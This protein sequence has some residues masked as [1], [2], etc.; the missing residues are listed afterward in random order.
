M[1]SYAL[2]WGHHHGSGKS[3]LGYTLL[4][5]FGDNGAEISG[6]EL[7]SA[8]NGYAENKQF[9]MADEC[10]DSDKRLESG[11]FKT[12]I[13][14]QQIRINVK[15][16]PDYVMPDRINYYLTSNFSD[17]VFLEDH[18]RRA[19]I[20]EVVGAPLPDSFYEEYKAWFYGDGPSHLFHYLLTLDL[21]NFNPMAK[22]YQTG[23]KKAMIEENRSDLSSF[24]WG[25]KEDPDSVLRIQGQ[26]VKR[27]LWT[28]GELLNIYDPNQRTRVTLNGIGRELAKAGVGKV[29][30]PIRTNVGQVN[31]YILRDKEVLEKLPLAELGKI[32]DRERDNKLAKF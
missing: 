9:V 4:R 18:D 3:L 32:F 30:H 12:A 2:I 22:A 5:I 29:K 14:R 17:S 25:V 13:S 11:R 7:A 1:P 27:R 23:A 31:L 24:C 6:P 21:G 28:A 20:L 15:F 26:V 10:R 8:F 19:F 16:I